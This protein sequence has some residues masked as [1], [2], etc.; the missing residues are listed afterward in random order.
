MELQLNGGT[1]EEK[2]NWAYERFEKTVPVGDV[3]KVNEM[4]DILGVTKGHGFTGVIKR[5]GVKKLPR[6]TH[7]GLRKIACIGAWHPS[8]VSWTVG[9]AG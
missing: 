5:Y 1:I 3:F 6:K 4:I 7:K 8:K 9:R 2:V